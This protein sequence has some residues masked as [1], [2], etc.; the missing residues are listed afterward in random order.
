[1]ARQSPRRRLTDQLRAAFHAACD[2]GDTSIAERLLN[3]LVRRVVTPP[4]H[5]DRR[6][7][8]DMAGPCE[9]LANLQLHHPHKPSIGDEAD[10]HRS[11]I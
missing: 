3:V 5:T 10:S 1:M 6:K 8:E 11:C 4:G 9:R 7:P 2:G